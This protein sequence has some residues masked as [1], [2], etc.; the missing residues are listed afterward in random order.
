[1]TT[2]IKL[3]KID[4]VKQIGEIVEKNNPSQAE[5]DDSIYGIYLLRMCDILKDLESS[6]S[7]TSYKIKSKEPVD[8]LKEMFDKYSRTKNGFLNF[9]KNISGLTSKSSLLSFAIKIEDSLMD[10]YCITIPINS[11]ATQTEL[12]AVGKQV[13]NIDGMIYDATNA[14]IKYLLGPKKKVDFDKNKKMYYTRASLFDPHMSVQN[15]FLG[16]VVSMDNKFLRTVGLSTVDNSSK[17][18]LESEITTGT[19][20]NGKSGTDFNSFKFFGLDFKPNPY[21]YSTGNAKKNKAITTSTDSDEIDKLLW[22]KELGDTLQSFF[23]T[24]NKSKSTES[25]ICLTNDRG[26]TFN[27]LLSDANFV[28]SEKSGSSKANN[29]K[30]MNYYFIKDDTNTATYQTMIKNTC[31]PYID[32]MKEQQKTLNKLSKTTVKEI[33]LVGS[34]NIVLVVDKTIKTK[35]NTLSKIIKT[36]IEIMEQV[37]TDF[38]LDNT[39]TSLSIKGQITL[40]QKFFEIFRFNKKSISES[41][42]EYTLPSVLS[43]T[44]LNGTNTEIDNFIVEFSTYDSTEMKQIYGNTFYNFITKL[45]TTNGDKELKKLYDTNT[46]IKYFGKYYNKITLSAV[47]KGGS[48]KLRGETTNKDANLAELYSQIIYK[49]IFNKSFERVLSIIEEMKDSNCFSFELKKKMK[50]LLFDEINLPETLKKSVTNSQLKR[51]IDYFNN[52]IKSSPSS[53]TCANL[54]K[55]ILDIS[56]VSDFEY[57][58]IKYIKDLV[59]GDID[60]SPSK[61]NIT[62]SKYVNNVFKEYYTDKLSLYEFRL[63]SLLF[64][65]FMAYKDNIIE[66]EPEQIKETITENITETQKETEETEEKNETEKEKEESRKSPN[67]KNS[68]K[69]SQKSQKKFS[70][71]KFMNLGFLNQ[72]KE[73]RELNNNFFMKNSKNSIEQIKKFQIE[74]KRELNKVKKTRRNELLQKYPSLK[75]RLAVNRI[76]THTNSHSYSTSSA[77][78]GGGLI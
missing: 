68:R 41:K 1:M 3:F 53:K 45:N 21:T 8:Y 23:I 63:Y 70:F 28:F 24:Q 73:S 62:I 15:K 44:I 16:E 39:A 19:T 57:D 34:N 20:F 14:D 50:T 10:K 36:L 59:F 17:K 60:V 52:I 61:I 33:P 71:K 78:A 26:F 29:K 32:E 18:K 49:E 47:L 9:L 69:K 25:I 12:D 7:G 75:N 51:E 58:Y 2:K 6:L 46:Y 40:I 4:S 30:F 42:G 48:Y 31:E 35:I 27:C 43:T 72:I 65:E 55:Y 64:E 13:E 38:L 77:A 37:L 56:L 66:Y 76:K 11:N 22:A 74:H 54:K 5:I 67:I